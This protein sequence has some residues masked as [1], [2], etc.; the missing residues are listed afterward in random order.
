MR[1]AFIVILTVF[2]SSLQSQTNVAM[3]GVADSTREFRNQ[4]EQESYW[5]EQFFKNNYSK[6][7][8][9]KYKGEVV[10]KGNSFHYADQTLEVVNTPKELK[11]V[12]STGLFYPSIL[13]GNNRTALKSQRELEM[14]TAEQKVFYEIS[15]TDSFSISNFEELPSLSKTPTQKRFRFWLQRKG[16]LNPIVCF[17]ELTNQSGGDHTDMETFIKGAELTYYKEGWIII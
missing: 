11:A 15:R 8:F 17:L 4:G 9:D 10:V 1:P 6:Q 5:A 2:I 3:P 14:L 13:T 12:F 7:I 16:L